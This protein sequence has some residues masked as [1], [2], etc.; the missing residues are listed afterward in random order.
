M[1]ELESL[2]EL[3]QIVRDTVTRQS[4]PHAL[5]ALEDVIN[6]IRRH[7]KNHPPRIPVSPLW[8]MPK[9]GI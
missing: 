4:D 9:G 8:V 7:D 6:A 5:W 2:R 1:T 3:L